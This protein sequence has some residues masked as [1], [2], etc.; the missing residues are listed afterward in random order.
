MDIEYVFMSE[1]VINIYILLTFG[2]TAVTHAQLG[3]IWIIIDTNALSKVV[4]NPC[5]KRPLIRN[6]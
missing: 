5:V 2:I 6:T 1:T 4:F 3:K